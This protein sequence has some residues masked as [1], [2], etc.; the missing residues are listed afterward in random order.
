MTAVFVDTHYFLALLN[1]RDQ[2]HKQAVQLPRPARMLTTQAVQIEV[3]GA[4]SHPSL[5]SLAVA[6]WNDTRN[7]PACK[8]FLW[9]RM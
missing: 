2:Y 8:S 4:L 5:R 3:M 1:P 6:F 7:D 9:R